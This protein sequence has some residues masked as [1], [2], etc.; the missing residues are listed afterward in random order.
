MVFDIVTL[1]SALADIF[2]DTGRRE[3]GHMLSYRI[4]YKYSV[5]NLDYYTGGGGTNTAVAF[6][7]LG[8]KTGALVKVGNDWFGNVIL[9]ELKKN[10]VKF[11]GKVA[12]E[13]TG[14][15]VILDSKERNRTI[16]S[17]KGAS[18][19]LKFSEIKVPETKWLY[20]SAT[21]KDSFKTQKKLAKIAKKKK[22]KIAYN[23]SY[24]LAEKGAAYLKD[25]LSKTYVLVLNKEEAKALVRKGDLLKGLRKLGPK[26]ICITDG[27]NK[28]TAYDGKS[29]Y[30]AK[31]H[32]IKP[33][34]TT[35]AGDAF[36]SGFVAALAKGK[37]IEKAIQL[38]I[39]NS[40]SV[41]KIKG[42]KNG[43]LKSMNIKSP[44]KV[45]IK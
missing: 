21:A 31:P 26:I 44:V 28:L 35:G 42:A 37:S 30:Y 9:K 15:S 41:I 43:L 34:E 14:V 11:L 10:K 7:K 23:I 17:Y 4:G 40:E 36:A 18:N 29:K 27:K 38:G 5:E 24:Y 22:I 3:K 45:I 32:G 13:K 20:F 25:I 19:N 8:L 6:A 1:G 2:V 16:L 33:V 12:R 39:A